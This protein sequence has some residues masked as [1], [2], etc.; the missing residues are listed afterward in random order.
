MLGGC[1]KRVI[2]HKKL[3]PPHCY[4]ICS[5]SSVVYL[6]KNHY[7][8]YYPNMLPT[9]PTGSW[10]IMLSNSVADYTETDIDITKE[11]I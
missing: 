4:H 7:E 3:P 2:S 6:D 1:I 5:N 9:N 11:I 10:T 8:H